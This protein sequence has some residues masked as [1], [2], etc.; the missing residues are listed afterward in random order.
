M[1][2][3]YWHLW[4]SVIGIDIG[5]I[6]K[7]ISV[8]ILCNKSISGAVRMKCTK[9]PGTLTRTYANEHVCIFN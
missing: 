1:G 7:S 6:I 4:W 8:A 5:Y 2:F 3:N 9:V